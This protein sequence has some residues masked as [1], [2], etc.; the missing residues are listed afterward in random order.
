M[1]FPSA[2]KDELHSTDPAQKL[3]LLLEG[4]GA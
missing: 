4:K 1:H 3:A 2:T